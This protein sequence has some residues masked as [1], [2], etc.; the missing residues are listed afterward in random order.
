MNWVDRLVSDETELGREKDH[1]MKALQVNC[2]PDW[3][4]TYAW[5]SDQL[6]PGQEE[7]VDGIEGEEEKDEVDQRVPA[8]TT[9]PEG[10]CV[11]VPKNKY[12][13]VLLY[14]RD[15]SEQLRRVF[16]S[17][18]IPAYFKLTTPSSNYWYDPR[19]R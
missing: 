12:Q 9:A 3:M 4:L 15:F 19:T 8:T 13:L 16:R 14:V 5:M 7:G 1:I 10:P 6:N 17:F 2:S 18:D 11:S